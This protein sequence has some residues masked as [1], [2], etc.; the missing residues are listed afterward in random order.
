[1]GGAGSK[2]GSIDG[3]GDGKRF[4][5]QKIVEKP[6]ILSAEEQSF[7]KGSDAFTHLTKDHCIYLPRGGYRQA[8]R[9]KAS[10]QR[11]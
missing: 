4:T 5:I 9:R 6:A 11:V 8:R 10:V 2:R 1:M 3:G 7:R